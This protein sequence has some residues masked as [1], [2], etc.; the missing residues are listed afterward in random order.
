MQKIFIL[1]T[2]IDD[3]SFQFSRN[4][5]DILNEDL[6]EFEVEICHLAT[7]SFDKK[8][9]LES[10]KVIMSGSM[11]SA[12][13]DFSWKKQMHE[14]MDIVLEKKIPTLAT[15]F[16]AQFLAFHLGVPVAKNPKGLEF[17]MV[18]IA[19]TKEGR[20]HRMLREFDNSRRVFASHYDYIPAVPKG[21]RL[22]ASNANTPVQAYEI[23]NVFATQFHTEVPFKRALS[24]LDE[25]RKNKI[26]GIKEANKIEKE[27]ED[28]DE[29]FAV[30]RRF[31]ELEK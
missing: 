26:L 27:I 12:Y 11:R 8:K 7:D 16:A 19:L 3:K 15:C 10:D 5:R 13:E 18:Q 25:K 17:G 14:I 1:D 4:L 24:L 28:I 22:L 9:L 30:L 31:L 21:A 20:E 29:S 2:L 23:E 6:D